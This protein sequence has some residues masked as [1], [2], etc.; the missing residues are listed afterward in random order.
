MAKFKKRK[1]K[2]PQKPKSTPRRIIPQ[3]NAG[4]PNIASLVREIRASE[5]DAAAIAALTTRLSWAMDLG[6]TDALLSCEMNTNIYLDK[7]QE[8]ISKSYQEEK[9]TDELYKWLS[10][11]LLPMMRE[12]M[13]R[14]MKPK[15]KTAAIAELLQ[16]TYEK[17]ESDYANANDSGDADGGSD[18]SSDGAT[19]EGNAAESETG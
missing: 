12:E 13:L 3:L 1:P 8:N 18:E 19:P 16:K 7:I 17:A 5:D 9:M 10:Q 15:P 11:H 2:R 4:D 6:Q 14:Y